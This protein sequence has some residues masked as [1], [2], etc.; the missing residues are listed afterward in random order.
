MF[1]ARFTPHPLRGGTRDGHLRKQHIRV[2]G[3]LLRR[4]NAGS[5]P[6]QRRPNMPEPPQKR[7]PP[8]R[9]RIG[10]GVEQELGEIEEEVQAK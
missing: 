3:V 7:A 2:A 1:L 4:D 8:K 9:R 10:R 5:A 6:D